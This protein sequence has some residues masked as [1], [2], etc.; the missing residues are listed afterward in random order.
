MSRATDILKT[1]RMGL[2][3]GVIRSPDVEFLYSD[4]PKRVSMAQLV[5][6]AIAELTGAQP[7]PSGWNLVPDWVAF[8]RDMNVLTIHGKQYAAPLF[9]LNGFLAAPG[10]VLRIEEGLDGVVTFSKVVAAPAALPAD[11]ELLE[12]LEGMLAIEASVT[13]GQE[14]ELE[15]K[16]LPK[17]KAVAKAVRQ[18]WD[19]ARTLSAASNK[20]IDRGL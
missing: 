11:I 15:E 9:G 3:Q 10:T 2:Q 6:E 18:Q 12:A 8:D 13:Q 17:A 16:W 5:D 20:E 1:I 19:R 4:G 14:R 7:V